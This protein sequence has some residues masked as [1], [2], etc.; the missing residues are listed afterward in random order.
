MY[1]Q[2]E[3]VC[4]IMLIETCHFNQAALSFN[5]AVIFFFSAVGQD[6]FY[7]D[8]DREWFDKLTMI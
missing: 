6:I 4:L 8:T 5:T 3:S 1:T 2:P 7:N